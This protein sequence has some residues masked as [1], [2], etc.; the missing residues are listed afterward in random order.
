MNKLQLKK[1][2]KYSGLSR[3]EFAKK[4]KISLSTLNSWSYRDCKIPNNKALLIR[5]IFDLDNEK[6]I[7]LPVL[8][9]DNA[10]ISVDEIFNFILENEITILEKHKMFKLWISEKVYKGLA[11][12]SGKLDAK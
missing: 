11:E 8:K 6:N 3:D 7:N 12:I 4:L 9:K 1:I 2:I 5:E 10:T